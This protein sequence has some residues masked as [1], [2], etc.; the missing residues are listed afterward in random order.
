MTNRRLI[1]M[2]GGR[3]AA[4]DDHS[5]IP[6]AARPPVTRALTRCTAAVGAAGV[7]AALALAGGGTP[8][9]PVASAGAEVVGGAA[10]LPVP[11]QVVGVDP[12]AVPLAATPIV[13]Q[14]EAAPTVATTP[15]TLRAVPA[16]TTT[17]VPPPVAVAPPP[18][19]SVEAVI[20]EV[21]G[22]D[23]AA[24]VRVARCESHLDPAAVSRGGG[25]WGL[26]QIN[27]AHAGR[28]ARMGYRWEDLLDARVNALVARSIFQES[29]WRPWACRRAV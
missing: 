11:S 10:S 13:A 26:F 5:S 2:I 24:A 23:G 21:F 17:T 28:V 14:A 12:G 9:V 25:N 4:G 7:V 1:A 18:V 19:G 27:R 15:S 16:P 3:A 22:A 6:L 29:G 8:G 20:A